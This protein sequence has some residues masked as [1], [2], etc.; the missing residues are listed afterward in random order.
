MT[1]ISTFKTQD[2]IAQ[3]RINARAAEIEAQLK[4]QGARLNALGAS[5]STEERLDEI[6][7]PSE[8]DAPSELESLR[9]E[10]SEMKAQL[11]QI[12]SN[13]AQ[14]VPLGE[15]IW[16]FPSTEGYMQAYGRLS[17]IEDKTALHARWKAIQEQGKAKE[18]APA[19]VWPL[20]EKYLEQ[21]KSIPNHDKASI[22]K[23]QRQQRPDVLGKISTYRGGEKILAFDPRF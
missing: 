18:L 23:L 13:T 16:F 17:S 10:L 19:A 11:S 5:K 12:S 15:K 20:V 2:E 21:R 4:E 9:E 8:A 14:A 1:D 22:A 6:K 7:P 3:E